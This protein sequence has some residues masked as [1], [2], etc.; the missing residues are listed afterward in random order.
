MKWPTVE[1][2]KVCLS[3][4]Q[5]DP[6]KAPDSLFRYIDIAS[7]DKDNK[8]I[9]GTQ[10]ILGQHAPSR[11]RKVVRTGDVLVSTVRPNLNAVAVVPANLDGE[12]A[13]TGF[14]VLRPNPKLVD[15]RYLFYRTVTNDFVSY[16]VARM[17]GANYPAVTDGT[18]KQAGIPL[19]ALTEQRRI[20]E[21]LDQADQLRKFR[22]EADKKA[23]RVLPALF[24]KVFGDPNTNPKNWP[25]E[26]LADHVDIGTRLVDPNGSEFAGLPHI[27]AEHIEK[28]SG[29]ILEYATTE[30]SN[31][32]SN[33][34]IFS[35]KHVLYSKIRPYLNKVAFPRFSGVCSAD[36]YPLLPKNSNIS[37]WYLV[38]LL[39]SNA[40]LA[41]AQTHSDRL[42][43]PKLNKEQLGAYPLPLPDSDVIKKFDAQA[44]IVDKM[45]SDR[46]TAG[47]QIE[48]LFSTLLQRAF[49]G[50][51]TASWREA[52][53]KELLAEMEQQAKYLN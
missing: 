10:S 35:E 7:I 12:I 39:R 44:E 13:S 2:G 31:L 5:N 21:I 42:R 46:H 19:P 51:L 27:G 40:F 26:P 28:N 34:F 52:H 29:R 50:T 53:M 32:R 37:A 30:E 8:S 38:S 36:V 22:A 17:K 47:I 20:I 24:N 23:E 3:T 15:G 45:Q 16:Q 6:G 25:K 43:M 33:K 41:Y 49:S 11:A 18:V 14:C 48:S 1:I 9:I 4:E